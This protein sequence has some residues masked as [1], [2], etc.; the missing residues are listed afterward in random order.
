MFAKKSAA[1][2]LRRQWKG[3]NKSTFLLVAEWNLIDV[4]LFIKSI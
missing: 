4:L 1:M 2:L 3:Q